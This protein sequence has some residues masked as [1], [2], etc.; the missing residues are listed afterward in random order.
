VTAQDFFETV[1]RQ[2]IDVLGGQ[3]HRQNTLDGHASFIL[4]SRL[5]NRDRRH[6]AVEATVNFT[7]V[8]DHRDLYRHDFKLLADLFANGMFAAAAYAR[9]FMFKKFVDDFDT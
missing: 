9:Q 3:Q 5:F 8:F 4:L 1:K 6:L 7:Y 2:S